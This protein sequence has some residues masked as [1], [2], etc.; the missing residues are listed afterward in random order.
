MD[1]GLEQNDSF[2]RSPSIELEQNRENQLNDS[3][4][5][6]VPRH[7]QSGQNDAAKL[8]KFI[9]MAV[10][11][12]RSRM[13]KR[14]EPRWIKFLQPDNPYYYSKIVR[15]DK[16]KLKLSIQQIKK[17]NVLQKLL[18]TLFKSVPVFS[19]FSTGKFVW[20]IIT[21]VCL[22]YLMVT[23]PIACSFG[24]DLS[25][26]N[27]VRVFAFCYAV[28][29]V[30]SLVNLNT[31]T[32]ENGRIT[33]NRRIIVSN[34]LNR[35][36]VSDL[37]GNICVIVHSFFRLRSANY[38]VQSYHVSQSYQTE[39]MILIIFLLKIVQIQK[40]FKRLEER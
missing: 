7:E 13:I 6:I 24:I 4:F 30:D 34:Y 19:P 10:E 27:D 2:I 33:N 36:L 37:L 21:L 8:K 40:L 9:R 31:G 20:D 35:Y 38:L 5:K 1:F 22:I 28:L 12:L 16:N 14:L 18:L 3:G 23:L 17:R 26:I 15:E 25:L 32:Y 29:N 11:R 39:D